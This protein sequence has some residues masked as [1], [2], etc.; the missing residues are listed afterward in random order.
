MCTR[1]ILLERLV[2]MM[3]EMR[4]TRTS[5]VTASQPQMAEQDCE[6]GEENDMMT[7]A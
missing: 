6:E 7:T 5:S 4:H 1:I 3:C 2:L